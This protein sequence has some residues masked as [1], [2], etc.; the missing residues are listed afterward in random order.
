[1]AWVELQAVN[2][3]VL[4][5]GGQLTVAQL[6]ASG[7][8]AVATDVHVAD[9]PTVGQRVRVYV[10]LTKPG[11][12]RMVL[13]TAAAGFF[14][15]SGVPID[16]LLLL[17]TLVGIGLVASGACAL[18]QYVERE[19]DARMNRTALRPIPSGR[20]EA[21]VALRFSIALCGLG[22]LHLLAF[23]G[24]PTAAI[25]AATVVSYVWLYTPLK[26]RTWMATLVGAV[27]GALPIL[28]GA[29]AGSGRVTALGLALFGILFLWQMPHF[30][31]LA[32][33]YRHDYARGGFRLLTVDDPAGVRTAQQIVL[34][35]LAL[36]FVSLQPVLLGASGIL[37]LVSAIA[38]GGGFV[39]LGLAMA[40]RRD[41]RR[42]VR[43][44]L[45][46]VAYLPLLLLMMVVDRLIG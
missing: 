23:V 15:S 22:L 3:A 18:N 7:R 1:L 10:E 41:D 30:Y 6:P 43:L 37:Y 40:L 17:H 9:S 8:V 21:R 38:L 24:L 28:A 29:V 36:F 2:V 35:G 34:F 26:R 44:F 13:I 46:S 5:F 27:P 19:A 25:V 32:W 12:V 11:I 39:A 16:V 14:M 33:L 20:M 42:A 4:P 31:A 45:G